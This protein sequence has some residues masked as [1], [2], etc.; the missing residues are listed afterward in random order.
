MPPPTRLAAGIRR[1]DDAG[2]ATN[3]SASVQRWI[4]TPNH[5]LQ[6]REAESGAPGGFLLDRSFP[7]DG[8]Q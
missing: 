7:A 1:S 3:S 2:D 5:D 8:G 6:E 4:L